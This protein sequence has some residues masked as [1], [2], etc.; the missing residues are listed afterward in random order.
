MVNCEILLIMVVFPITARFKRRK[1]IIRI[2]NGA[3]CKIAPISFKEYA[4]TSSG[5]ILC[6]ENIG[7]I[8]ELN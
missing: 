8:V 2:S 3:K 7:I 5:K 4:S 6:S 1:I